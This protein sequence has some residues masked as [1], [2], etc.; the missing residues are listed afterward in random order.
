MEVR[1]SSGDATETINQ[2]L[3]QR[4]GWILTII[5][6]FV[7]HVC[8]VIL[9][10]QTAG[11]LCGSP[12]LPQSPAAEMADLQ[13]QTTDLAASCYRSIDAAA[14]PVWIL[15]TLGIGLVLTGVTVRIVGIRRSV[16]RSRNRPGATT[17]A[18]P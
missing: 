5:V 11:P 16:V 7:L 13:L 12:L 2:D 18:N 15:M 9:G 6:G 14:V 4:R 17:Q 8:S 3:G 10:L 1:D